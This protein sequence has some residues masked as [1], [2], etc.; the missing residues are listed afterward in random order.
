MYPIQS[1]AKAL[2]DAEQRQVIR[3]TGVDKNGTPIELAKSRRNDS[4]E[5]EKIKEYDFI[6]EIAGFGSELKVCR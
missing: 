4:T 6:A 3:I 1:A 2:F 5:S